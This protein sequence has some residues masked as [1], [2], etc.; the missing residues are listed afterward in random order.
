MLFLLVCS[1]LEAGFGAG[2]RVVAGN[3]STPALAPRG[4]VWPRKKA[5]S[6]FRQG[7]ATKQ[8]I[9]LRTL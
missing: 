8:K 3:E 2:K 4:T 9:N 6:T 5:P 7:P 1:T